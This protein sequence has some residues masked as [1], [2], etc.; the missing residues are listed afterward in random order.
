[1]K[2][3]IFLVC[4]ILLT[5]C[6]QPDNR[7]QQ[8]Q[9]EVDSLQAQ[10]NNVYRPG[11]GEFMSGIQ[12]HHNKLW[13]AGSNANWALANFELQ[14][15][16]EAIDDIKEYNTDRPETKEIGMIKPALDSLNE[17]IK[18]E[19][20]PNFKKSFVLLTATCNNCHR[21]TNHGFNHIMVPTTPPFSNQ[22]FKADQ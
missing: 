22:S 14:E 21:A 11:L 12:V 9:A 16:Q 1:M 2:T 10:L 7:I 19:D 3:H 20:L 17:S 15:I 13:F 18:Q 5:G 8:L 4:V 6:T